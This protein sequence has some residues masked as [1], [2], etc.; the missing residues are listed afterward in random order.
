MQ[1]CLHVARASGP[2]MSSLVSVGP[3][4]QACVLM[5]ALSLAACVYAIDDVLSYKSLVLGSLSSGER[6][7]GRVRACPS[8]ERA[9]FQLS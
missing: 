7:S 2:V 5:L 6:V 9:A 4:A 8:L 3:T 1:R